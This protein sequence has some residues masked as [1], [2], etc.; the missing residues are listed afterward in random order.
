MERTLSI[1]KPD[2]VG[3]KLIGEVIRRFE[4]R[5]IRI[6]AMKMVELTKEK[7]Q[8]FYNVH[9]ERPFFD[10]L[11][12]FMSSGPIVVMVLQGEN[13]IAENRKIGLGLMGWA[14]LLYRLELPYNSQKALNLA[15]TLMEFFQQESKEASRILAQ[16][17]GPFPA[18]ENSVYAEN[19]EGPYRNATTTTIAPTGTL[20]IIA[21]CS[22]GIEPLFAL[23]FVRQVMEG[24]RLSEL[25]QYFKQYFENTEYYTP[26]RLQEIAS[27]GTIR[28]LEYMPRRMKEIFVTSMDIEPV[29]HLYMQAAFQKHTD[30]A[31]SKTVN[32]PNSATQEDIYDIYWKAHEF[33]CKGVTVFRDGSK[34]EQVLT[35]SDHQVEEEAKQIRAMGFGHI[36]MVTGEHPQK[37]GVS[38]LRKALSQ[39]THHFPLVSMEVQPLD[40]GDYQTL[41]RE[42]LNTVYIYQETYHPDHYHR[43]HPAGPKA[44]FRYRIETPERLGKAGIHKAGLG[45]LLGLEDWRTDSF[46]TG[47]HLRYLQ[48]HYWRTQYSVSFPRLRP[49]AGSYPPNHTVSDRHL[50]QLIAAYRIF[51]ENVE[52]ALSTRE[53]A[54]FRDHAF[55]LGITSMSAGSSTQPGGY[56]HPK[57]QL[58]QFEVA[59]HRSPSEIVAMLESKGYEGVWKNWDEVLQGGGMR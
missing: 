4:N 17:K 31:V 5:D 55:Q 7:A 47:M 22:S 29:W 19:K 34:S 30:N 1:I 8:A 48:K 16:E 6:V 40:T 15:E 56:S 35:R 11:T 41:S 53:S 2:G 20:S 32:L 28:D 23:S 18:Y 37:T 42:G 12:D 26:D 21:G 27:R 14:D 10:S 38:Y 57:D 24:E 3:K 51:D 44:D 58:Q 39:L 49:F 33:G 59:D 46:F 45:I 9:R 36:L 54:Y 25:N 50:V 52:L 13:V 43:Y